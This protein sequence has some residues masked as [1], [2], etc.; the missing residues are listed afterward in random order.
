M[1]ALMIQSLAKKKDDREQDK[2]KSATLVWM[3]KV[4][5]CI[6]NNLSGIQSF[7]HNRHQ[8]LQVA[9]YRQDLTNIQ[10]S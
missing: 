8:W 9:L 5:N 4:T 2:Q 7:T 6:Q 3:V 1:K 10:D